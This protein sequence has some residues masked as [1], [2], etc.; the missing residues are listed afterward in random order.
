MGRAW[1]DTAVA[2]G[3]IKASQV[4]GLRTAIDQ[5]LAAAQLSYAW[6][7]ANVTP[8][9]AVLAKH[10]TELRAAIQQLWDFKARG[11][12]PAWTSGVT[13][14]GPSLGTAATP[15]R[16]SDVTDLRTWLNQ[17]EDNHPPSAQ[18][19]DSKSYDP[20]SPVHPV[21]QV[22]WAQDIKS[23]STQQ[24]LF[25]RCNVVAPTH[26]DFAP[27][28]KDRYKRHSTATGTRV[29]ESSRSLL[30]NST[31]VR[32]KRSQVIR[33]TLTSRTRTSTPS[34]TVLAPSR[35]TSAPTLAWTITSSGMS[36]TR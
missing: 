18:G 17:Y 23:L 35:P 6:T 34:S 27:G 32:E 10:F 13:P 26:E 19:V 30:G 7:W 3:P 29:C 25:V 9:T 28:D 11:P 31:R 16:A 33:W 15:I 5:D 12:L 14:G 24:P 1:P 22:D 2:G 36:L 21:I 8:G 4:S 20:N